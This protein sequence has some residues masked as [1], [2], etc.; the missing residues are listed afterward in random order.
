MHMQYHPLSLD[1]DDV[2]LPRTLLNNFELK[3]GFLI[4]FIR[5]IRFA[6]TLTNTLCAGMKRLNRDS[7]RKIWAIFC[8]GFF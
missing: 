3:G 5:A 6:Y 8:N 7:P 2:H 1:D 4:P